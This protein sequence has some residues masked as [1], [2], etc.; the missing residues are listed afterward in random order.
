MKK[1]LKLFDSIILGIV[2]VLYLLMIVSIGVLLVNKDEYGSIRLGN[3]H[4]ITIDA[5]NVNEKYKAGQL[6]VVQKID[7]KELKALDD[8]FIYQTPSDT[9]ST[10]LYPVTIEKI[11]FN[12]DMEY[13]SF[14]EEEGLYKMDTIVGKVIKVYNNLGWVTKTVQTKKIFFIVLII[15]CICIL[16][17]LIYLMVKIIRGDIKNSS[18]EKMALLEVAED[19]KC[20]SDGDDVIVPKKQEEDK[21]IFTTGDEAVDSEKAALEEVVVN[22]ALID[23]KGFSYEPNVVVPNGESEIPVVVEERTNA[24]VQKN[25]EA[26][27]ASSQEAEIIQTQEIKDSEDEELEVI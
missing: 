11:S 5:D 16:L 9:D 2:I 12:G 13:I 4:L 24:E 27:D 22:E 18:S 25:D 26:Q 8:V 20:V 19:A 6:V 23:K 7:V 15:P 1:G 14:V 21:F 17:Y 10:I 3:K